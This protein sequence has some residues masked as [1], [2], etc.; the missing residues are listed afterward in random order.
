MK[1]ETKPESG[2]KHL[3]TAFRLDQNAPNPFSATTT[4]RFVIARPCHVR[5]SIYDRE[6][7]LVRLL[8]DGPLAAGA[9]NM[10]WN[11]RAGDGQRLPNGFYNYRLQANGFVAT[12]KLEINHKSQAPNNK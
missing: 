5:V 8:H 7:K 11:G 1:P 3:P 4:I 12:R 6:R 2:E 10:E 9:Y